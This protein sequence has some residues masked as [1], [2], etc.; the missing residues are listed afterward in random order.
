MDRT[1]GRCL[2]CSSAGITLWKLLQFSP[3]SKRRQNQVGWTLTT[4]D[5]LCFQPPLAAPTSFWTRIGECGFIV[6]IEVVPLPGASWC[7]P[8]P[9]NPGWVKCLVMAEDWGWKLWG[10]WVRVTSGQK[11]YELVFC[12][13]V[14]IFLPLRSQKPMSGWSLS[15]PGSLSGSSEETPLANRQNTNSK[16]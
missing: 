1:W 3:G 15:L 12:L 11:L 14:L 13:K 9:G 16:N 5:K 8:A 2:P 6:P 7:N 10:G 4:R